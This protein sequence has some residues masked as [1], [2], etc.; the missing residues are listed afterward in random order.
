[1]TIFIL[2][3]VQIMWKRPDA[4]TNQILVIGDNIQDADYKTRWV[5]YFILHRRKKTLKVLC[6]CCLIGRYSLPLA[7]FRQNTTVQLCKVAHNSLF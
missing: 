2:E 5:L 7:N 6:N 3:Q 4:E 1:M